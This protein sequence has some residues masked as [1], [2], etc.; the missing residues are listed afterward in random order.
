M[1][2]HDFTHSP[3]ARGPENAVLNCSRCDSFDSLSIHC[4]PITIDQGDPH[5][6]AQHSDGT[7]RCMA[8]TRSLLGQV[9]LGY[10]N[11]LNQLTSFLDAS[12]VYGSTVCKFLLLLHRRL[13]FS[14]EANSLRLFSGGKLNFTDLGFNREALPQG[15]QERDCRTRQNFPCF[16]A[17]DER[18]NIQPGLATVHTLMMREHNRVAS[19]L[20]K[21][22]NFWADERLYQEARRIVTAKFQHIVYSEW[23]PIVLGCETAAKYILF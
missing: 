16:N 15:A 22:N 9:T 19:E 10:R 2:D 3:L 23:L 13:S 11:Q 1:L 14:G 21:L 18:N 6:P 17:G 7:P 12:H 8:F 4:F 5:Y 20:H